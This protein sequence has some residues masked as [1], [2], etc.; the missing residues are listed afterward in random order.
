MFIYDDNFLTDQEIGYV[1]NVFEKTQN[2][3]RYSPSSVQSD[4]D[5]YQTII[6]G[7]QYSDSPFFFVDADFDNDLKSMSKVLIDKFTIKNNIKYNQILRIRFNIN[8]SYHDEIITFPHVDSTNPHYVFLYYVNDSSGDTIIYNKKYGE[9]IGNDM[10]IM[11][12]ITPKKGSAFI[13]DGRHFHSVCIPT[14]GSLRKVINAN[15]F[16]INAIKNE[17]SEA[18]K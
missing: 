11:H 4:H 6:R 10:S 5:N 13:M 3:W 14:D 17:K 2:I 15:L 18:K 1:Q 8:P 7:D 16:S 12:R 9:L